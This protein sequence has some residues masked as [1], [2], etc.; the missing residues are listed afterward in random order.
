MQGLRYAASCHNVRTDPAP[1]AVPAA[2]QGDKPSV[3]PIRT[4][5]VSPDVIGGP[6]INAL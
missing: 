1:R 2:T 5:D 3:V 4:D 6:V